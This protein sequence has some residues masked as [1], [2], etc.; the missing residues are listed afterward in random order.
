M[1]NEFIISN[2]QE[3]YKGD[4]EDMLKVGNFEVFSK[5]QIDTFLDDLGSV[6]EKAESSELNEEDKRKIEIAK[7]EVGSFSKFEVIDNEFNKS[8]KYVRP[9]QIEWDVNEETG[10]IMKGEVGTYLNTN[11]NKKLGRVGLKYQCPSLEK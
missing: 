2:P 7:S 8:L 5:S 1:K 9:R 11:L 6:L 4:F 3:V 10:N